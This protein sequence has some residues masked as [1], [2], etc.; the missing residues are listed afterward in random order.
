MM[1][2][3]DILLFYSNKLVNQGHYRFFCNCDSS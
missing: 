3:K 2:A 1:I